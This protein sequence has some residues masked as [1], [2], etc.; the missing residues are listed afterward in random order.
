MRIHPYSVFLIAFMAG[1]AL[2][3][4]FD[5]EIAVL[6]LLCLFFLGVFAIV[7]VRQALQSYAPADK[8]KSSSDLPTNLPAKPRP[9]HV[10]FIC[11]SLALIYL[12]LVVG[13]IRTDLALAVHISPEVASSIG[14]NA[15]L[16]GIVADEPIHKDTTTHILVHADVLNSV[17]LGRNEAISVLLYADSSS[18]ASYG[19]RV[20]ASG[21]LE[22]PKDFQDK[23]GR[24]VPYQRMLKKDGVD[25]VMRHA[26]SE[27][28]GSSGGSSIV[29]MIFSG[30]EFF[31]ASV[32]R[33]IPQ[34]E[35]ALGL[36]IFVGD[37]GGNPDLDADLRRV[38]LSYIVVISG[39]H[40]AVIARSIQGILGTIA[41]LPGIA[42]FALSIAAIVIFSI[43]VGA[44]APVMRAAIM[45]ILAL[46]AQ[47]AGRTYSVGRALALAG[48]AMLF[49]NP[50]ILAYDLSFQLTFIAMLAIIYIE[51]VIERK[52]WRI[53]DYFGMRGIVATTL[54]A[55]FSI[56]PLSLAAFGTASI[57]SVASSLLIMPLLPLAM[58]LVFAVG[59]GSMLIFKGV[60]AIGLLVAP[61]AFSARMLLAWMLFIIHTLARFPYAQIQL[62]ITWW[63]AGG[64]YMLIIALFAYARYSRRFS[65]KRFSETDQL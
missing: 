31:A 33:M 4:L 14:R 43:A 46:I 18:G 56:L 64:L 5:L 57:E 58:S 2:R 42:S 52:L 39:I 6:I 60:P 3:S 8:N 22:F 1:I 54:A 49:E 30:K 26:A 55:E 51:P 34:S 24:T 50:L 10:I 48:S 38:G 13:V 62:P 27:T 12:G 53:P 21:K 9:D 44:K 47:K 40:L 11:G 15:V 61:I 23:D 65:V 20:R 19:D 25:M 36:G 35:A 41:F 45:A 16:E 29:K 28:I 37:H 59:I 7:L 32:E 63:A 17:P